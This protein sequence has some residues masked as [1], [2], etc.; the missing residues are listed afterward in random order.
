MTNDATSWYLF[1]HAL[2]S[3]SRTGYAD[4]ILTAKILPEGIPPI[5]RMAHYLSNVP[6]SVNWSSEILRCTQTT[7][8]ISKITGR[9]FTTDA[10]LNEYYNES[11]E[12]FQKRIISWHDEMIKQKPSVVL[13]CTHGGVIAGVKHLLLEGVYPQSQNL[14]YPECGELLIISGH[15]QQSISFN[16]KAL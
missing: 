14:D 9:T 11:F 3:H 1:R 16:L 6:N 4:E 10:R 8:I 7:Q 2:A 5:E 12:T 15:S 13:V